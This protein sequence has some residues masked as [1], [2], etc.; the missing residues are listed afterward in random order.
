MKRDLLAA[1]ALLALLLVVTLLSSRTEPPRAAT[2]ASTDYAFGGY[3]AWYEL[4]QR[5]GYTPERFRRHHDAL[6]E[7]GVTT[8]IVAFPGGGIAET[9]NAAEA[10]A[11]AQWVDGGGRAVVLGAIPGTSPDA[12]RER[13]ARLRTVEGEQPGA[14]RGPWSAQVAV[15]GHR[16]TARLILPS[17]LHAQVLLADAS[18]ALVARYRSGRGTYLAVA[19]AAALENRYLGEGDAARLAYLLARP[20]APGGVIAFDEA[21]RGDIVEKPWYRTLDAPELL[22]LAI[23][24]LAGLLWLVYGIIPLGPPVRIF[25]PRE[26]TSA[27]FLDAVAAL[28]GRAEARTHARDALLA[29]AHRTLER[30]PRTAEN[31]ALLARIDAAAQTDPADDGALIAVAHLARLAREETVRATDPDR[32]RAAPAR[33]I[34]RDR[35]RR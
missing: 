30:A 6:A 24:A 22:A 8:L 4:E 14:L 27:E 17:A 11:L 34:G 7:S 33:R 12:T 28:Y 29:E 9:W 1:A 20:S 32:H 26:P 13:G 19:S 21:L 18:G 35:R 16:G 31:A 5:E 23:A 25:A 10:H 2:H 15:L 3:R